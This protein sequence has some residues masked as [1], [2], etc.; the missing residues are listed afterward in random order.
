MKR[1]E[2]FVESG[3]VILLSFKNFNEKPYKIC[4]CLKPNQPFKKDVTY[5]SPQAPLAQAILFHQVGEEIEYPSPE[6]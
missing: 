6:D 3:K 1:K 4:I 5:I 2:G